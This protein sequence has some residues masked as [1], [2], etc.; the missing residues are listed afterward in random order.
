MQEYNIPFSGCIDDRILFGKL[1]TDTIESTVD[2]LRS[3]VYGILVLKIPISF[4]I[5]AKNFD[6]QTYWS[7]IINTKRF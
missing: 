6:L 1:W 3:K 7:K 4:S 5:F 2:V